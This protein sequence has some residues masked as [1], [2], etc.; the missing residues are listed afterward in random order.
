MGAPVVAERVVLDCGRDD[1]ADGEPDLLERSGRVRSM[2]V[3]CF[4]RRTLGI[5]SRGAVCIPCW[6]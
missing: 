1:A 6:W 2:G 5:V 3:D 4:E